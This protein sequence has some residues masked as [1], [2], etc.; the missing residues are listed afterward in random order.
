MTRNTAK[1]LSYLLSNPVVGGLGGLAV[2]A[3][4]KAFLS[5]IALNVL[6]VL[7]FYS[8][9]PFVSVYFLRLQGRTD[10]FMSE[11][12]RRPKHFT[13]GL[14]GYAASACVFQ[15][16][17]MRLMRTASASFL[18]TSL[19]LLLLTLKTKVSIHVAGLTSTV[20]LIIY[21]YGSYGLI[22]LPLIPVLAWARVNTGEHNFQ[23]TVLGTLTGLAGS[24]LGITVL[25]PG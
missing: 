1:A 21:S 7:L 8:L 25:P 15:I 10:I 6:T 23:H 12:R 17:G 3:R 13:P 19:I 22:L 11:R 24:L 20:V 14:I 5:N 16:W 4:E 2:M 18:A 9:I